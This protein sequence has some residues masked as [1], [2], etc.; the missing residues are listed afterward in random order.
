MNSRVDPLVQ[1]CQQG[2]EKAFYILFKQYHRRVQSIAFGMVRNADWIE[3]IL[4]EVF[5]RVIRSIG[6]FK[7]DCKFTT[8]LYRITV[9]TTLNFLEK[10]KQYIKSIPLEAIQP[11]ARDKGK[12]PH[13]TAEDMEIYRLAIGEVMALPQ[14]YR[15]IFYLY[16]YGESTIEEIEKNT[17][18]S[19]SAIKSILFRAR[20]NIVRAFKSK[21]LIEK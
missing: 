21:G 7:G 2:D 11:F 14:E 4:Q 3:D 15:E 8:W 13:S 10:E 1:R 17:G 19:S 18:K 9:N 20:K 12:D 5:Q 6:A 16:Y